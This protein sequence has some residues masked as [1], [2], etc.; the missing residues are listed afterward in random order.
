MCT[1]RDRGQSSILI[2]EPFLKIK[3]F[4]KLKNLESLPVTNLGAS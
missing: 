3:G 2:F 1:L 4:L